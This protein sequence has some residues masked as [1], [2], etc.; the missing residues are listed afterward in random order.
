MYPAVKVIIGMA[1]GSL[2]LGIYKKYKSYALESK[3]HNE[4]Q[5]M[6]KASI[7]IGLSGIILIFIGSI[8]GLIL[9]IISYRR[10]KFKTLSVIGIMVSALTLL[11]WLMVLIFG[12]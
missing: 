4:S 2:I 6:A 12:K 7:I 5:K 11:P 10:K 8:V 1:I 9:G 3:A